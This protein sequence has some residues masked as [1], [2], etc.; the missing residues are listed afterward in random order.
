[1]GIVADSES[2]MDN[3]AKII[4]ESIAAG[5][6]TQSVHDKIMKAIH[7]DG[8]IDQEESK[9]LSLLFQ[10]TRTGELRIIDSDRDALGPSHLLNTHKQDAIERQ[11]RTPQ[12]VTTQLE[13]SAPLAEQIETISDTNADESVVDTVEMSIPDT[14]PN[15]DSL[16]GSICEPRT[17]GPIFAAQN[18]RLLDVALNGTIWMRT[19]AMVGYYGVIK[20]TR[21]GVFEHGVRKLMKKGATGEG[22][23]LTKAVGQGNLYLADQGKKIS[24]IDLC[25][26]AMVVNGKN[27]LAFE[28][29]VHWDISFL[30]QFAAVVA[31]GWFNVRLHGAGMAAITTHFDP[32]VLRV[33]PGRPVMTD[34]NA[35][36]AWSGGLTPQFKTD[37]NRQTMIGRSS[38]E[39]VQM[40]FQ[41]DGHVIIQPYEEVAAVPGTAK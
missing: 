40:T 18:D 5:E 33:T 38:G 8:Q 17:E 4:E 10:A 2:S 28:E 6:M 23:S 25:G 20:F 32:I 41:G 31:G 14:A 24:I 27:I 22:A 35:T 39:T 21:E 16:F 11:N 34:M 15:F 26:Q 36:V 9:L 7:R 37:I 12:P 3:L 1:M 13:P 19:G 29:S 30:K